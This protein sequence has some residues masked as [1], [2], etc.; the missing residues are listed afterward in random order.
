[1][2]KS[3]FVLVSVVAS[4]ALLSACPSKTPPPESTVP[5]A[6][7]KK[8]P[9]AAPAPTAK[10]APVPVAT[11]VSPA[12]KAEAHQ[13][14][15]QRCVACHGADGKGDGP[16]AAALNPKP[17]NY[18]DPTFQKTVSDQTIE[19]AI[20]QGG[21]A[22]GKSPL[23]P[24]NPDLKNQPEVVAALKDVVRTFGTK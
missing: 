8:A 17:Q 10:A 11:T 23:M 18:T 5:S 21:A 20:V 2:N 16:A 4:G 15:E 6:S 24:P 14:F 19:K 12:A 7:A 3:L 22:V 13:I 1:M 9:A